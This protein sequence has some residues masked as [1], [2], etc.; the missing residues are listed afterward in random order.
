MRIH[1][2]QHVPFEGLGSL[3]EWIDRGGHQIAGTRLYA[4]DGLPRPDAVEL[5]IVLG[6]PMG[7]HDEADYPWLR[8]EKDFIR[9]VAEAGGGVLGICLGAQLLA[10]VLGARI[11]RNPAREIGWFPVTRDPALAGH[12]LAERLPERF[13]AFHWH[14]ETFSLPEGALPVGSTAACACQGFVHGDRLLGFQFHLETTPASAQA[15]VEHCADELDGSEWVQGP[16]QLLAE[17]APFGEINALMTQ[18][19]EGLAG[20]LQTSASPGE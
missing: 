4:G 5:L 8:V 1:F 18:V 9:R 12:W 6:G 16:A 2:L 11:T 13:P 3:A 17:D 7:V 19:M 15:L 10:E 14:G 20:Q